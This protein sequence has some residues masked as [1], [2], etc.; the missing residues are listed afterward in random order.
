MI[1]K[2]KL[3]LFLSATLL[4]AGQMFAS[5][6]VLRDVLYKFH[7]M[8]E[9]ILVAAHRGAHQ[10]YPENSLASYR[11]AIRLGVDIIETDV[12]ATKDGVLVIMHDKTVDRTTNGK[13][14]VCDLTFDELRRL[15]LV[16]QGRITEELIP[17]F[18]E[19]LQLTKGKIMLDVDFKAERQFLQ[20]T[21]Q[22]IQQAGMENQV[23]FFL[24]DYK[25]I[26]DLKKISPSTLIM[27]RAYNL[28][29]MSSI[30]KMG[31]IPVIHIDPSYYKEKIIKKYASQTRIW[32]NALGKYDNYENKKE[33]YTQMLNDLKCVNI[34]QTDYPEE[35]IR[36]LEEK[37]REKL[38]T[39][40]PVVLHSEIIK[41]P[42]S[43]PSA[44]ASTIVETN[45]GL[46]V[47]WFGG[48]YERHPDVSVYS[49][50]F[51]NGEWSDPVMLTNGV[52][53]GSLRYPCWNPVLFKRGNGDLILYYKVGPSPSTWWGEYKISTDEGKTWSEMTTIP[54]ACVGPIKNKPV[55][56][57]GGKI[58]YPT[59]I[60]I[61][62]KWN[63]YMEKSNQDLTNWE[64]IEIDNNHFDAIQPS[65]L[66]YK[67]GALQILCR[68]KNKH[69]VESW[70]AD[71]GESWSKLMATELPNNNSG[72]DAVT[73]A[74]KLQI[75]IYNPIV[76]GRNK[77]AIAGSF[78]GKIWEKLI[79]LEDQPTGEYSYP[80]IIQDK[81]GMVHVV[82]TYKRERIKY[83]QLKFD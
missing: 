40:K 13:G 64:K 51:K 53:N 80:A 83:V 8:P 33:G 71:N 25:Q 58:L 15:R 26:P 57:P 69:I 17:A 74:N 67:D 75:I 18:E 7:Y 39:I 20:Q 47:A 1:S 78:D 41:A 60:E 54:R 32:A 27:P 68:S 3:I 65:V 36:F 2:N 73:L 38:R 61:V 23:L 21:S 55:I 56:I 30:I 66:F 10:D 9:R 70:S 77:L 76:E 42:A 4:S 49:S 48:S 81:A 29:D 52:Q 46:L 34:I 63:V 19:V 16:H 28:K 14:N 11:E 43:V 12:R 62:G 24:Y 31:N 37:E 72:T 79:D 82:Y 6:S 35:L 22:A 45:D 44:H 59:S 50:R 5:E